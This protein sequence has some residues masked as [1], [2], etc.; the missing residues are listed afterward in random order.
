MYEVVYFLSAFAA[1]TICFA[2]SLAAFTIESAC[3]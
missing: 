3:V 1:S 2:S